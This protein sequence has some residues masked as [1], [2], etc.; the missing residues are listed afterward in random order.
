MVTRDQ[1]SRIRCT[2]INPIA[3]RVVIVKSATRSDLVTRGRFLNHASGEFVSI[4]LKK[5]IQSLKI[6]RMDKLREGMTL[7]YVFASCISSE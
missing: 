5:P 1:S 3:K 7:D 2:S 4:R 6:S